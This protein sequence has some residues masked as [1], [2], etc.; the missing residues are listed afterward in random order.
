ME[1]AGCV[2]FAFLG[3]AEEDVQQE[4][5]I[6]D[7]ANTRLH[8]QEAL[9]ACEG[10]RHPHPMPLETADTLLPRARSCVCGGG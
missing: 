5:L 8:A 10:A 7:R 6:A 2:I 1:G 4:L 3:G 9:V